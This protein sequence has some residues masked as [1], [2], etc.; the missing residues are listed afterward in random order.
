MSPAFS[1]PDLMN[2]QPDHTT[3]IGEPLSVVASDG[4]LLAARVFPN[5]Q[6]KYRL[7]ISH[8]NGLA[9]FGYRVFWEALRA[10]FEII[11]F[12]FRGHGMSQPGAAEQHHWPQLVTDLESLW[13]TLEQRRGKH[14]TVGVFHSMSAVTSLLQAHRYGRRWDALVL[15][16]PPVPPPPG[17]PLDARHLMEV[18]ALAQKARH[19]RP[20]YESPED[21]AERF[22]RSSLFGA[23]RDSA[24]LDMARASLHRDLTSGAWML[25]CAPEREAHIYQTNLSRFAWDAVA[26]PPCPVHLISSDPCLSTAQ[27]PSF[28]SLSLHQETA[29][30]YEAISGTGHF[31]QL[32]QPEPCRDALR[33]FLATL[34]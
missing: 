17:H 15:F 25:N 9:V 26:G 5:A 34:P 31:L 2:A 7:V 29:V 16:D 11:A 14:Q 32:E 18:Q 1:V 12:D 19:R 20:S 8:G 13:S 28:A 27:V 33:R 22:G 6:A 24:P 10:E 4:T 23:W 30:S 21:L 3:D